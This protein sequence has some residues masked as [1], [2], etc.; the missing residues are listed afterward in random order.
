M[1]KL[2]AADDRTLQLP[3]RGE[4]VDD[5]K[6]IATAPNG[7]RGQHSESGAKPAL[8]EKREHIIQQ[9]RFGR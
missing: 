4:L 5:L 2:D 1:M 8:A 9:A 7:S 6:T 3:E